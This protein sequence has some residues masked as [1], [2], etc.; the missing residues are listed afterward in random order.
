MKVLPV[1]VHQF[2]SRSQDIRSMEY[3]L[4]TQ[5][6]NRP[7]AMGEESYLEHKLL[8]HSIHSIWKEKNISAEFW[9]MQS[10]I[11]NLTVT[12]V[13][14]PDKGHVKYNLL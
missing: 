13:T 9:A 14:R 1:E 10:S 6:A 8:L 2:H 3:S 7:T 11:S 5:I 12:S 4:E